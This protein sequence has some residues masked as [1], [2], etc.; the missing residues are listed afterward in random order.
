MGTA[1][2][3]EKTLAVVLHYNNIDLSTEC[4]ASLLQATPPVAI[5]VLDN[6][7]E[8]EPAAPLRERFPMIE[9]VRIERNAGI[10]GGFNT[11]CAI[12]LAKG[13]T[14]VALV[15][16]DVTVDPCAIGVMQQALKSDPSAGIAGPL[17]YYFGDR[18]RVWAAGAQV[19]RF[20]GTA[21][22]VG[23]DQPD[24]GQFGRAFT[25][26]FVPGS[27]WMVRREVFET[28]GMLNEQ[29]FFSCEDVDFSLRARQCGWKTIC[30]PAAKVWHR[31]SASTAHDP[32]RYGYYYF[33]R[34][35]LYLIWNHYLTTFGYVSAICFLNIAR[36]SIVFGWAAAKRGKW[37]ALWPIGRAWLDFGRGRMGEQI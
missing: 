27:I 19:R 24:T 5:L 15:S 20:R 22:L 12:A 6:G 29:L 18:S 25:V 7:S 8:R 11:G 23:R 16:N 33:T 28:I 30:E 36:I 4:V 2:S 21:N 3:H 37:H 14:F 31:V 26:D 1:V 10:T 35:S 34:N 32:S 17:N 13:A 9:I